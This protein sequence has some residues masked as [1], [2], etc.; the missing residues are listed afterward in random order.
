MASNKEPPPS[1]TVATEKTSQRGSMIQVT[2]QTDKGPIGIIGI[3]Y[4]NLRRMKAGMPLSIDIKQ[5]TPPG[6]RMNQVLVHYA[7]T[8][9]QSVDD[10]ATSGL[11]VTDALRQTAK[12]MDDR[13][14]RER[15]G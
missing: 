14:K 4:E 12:E 5:I 10:M 13:L 11:P 8:Y 1:V 15:R 6:T 3:N 9:V 2:L 7:D